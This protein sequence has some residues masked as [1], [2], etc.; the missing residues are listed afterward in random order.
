MVA[1]VA[2]NISDYVGL[3]INV[4]KLVSTVLAVMVVTRYGRKTFTL[5]GNLSL[6]LIDIGIA[7]F[8][9]LH[10][11]EPSGYLIFVLLIGFNVV[12]GMTLGP[13]VLLYVP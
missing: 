2:P 13:V 5:L 12:Y 3:V 1:A 8:F 7:L 4:I 9:V 10:S 11:W 6:G